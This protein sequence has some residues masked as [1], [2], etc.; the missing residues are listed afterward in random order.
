MKLSK[1]LFLALLVFTFATTQAQKV[2]IRAGLNISNI[3][4]S[5]AVD[6]KPLTGVYFGVFKEITL[7]P[8]IFYLQPELQYSM[9]GYKSGD[10][11]FS[12]GY[13]NIPVLA[14]VYA[15]KTFSLEAGPQ[16]G[17]KV[18]DNFEGNDG[19]NIKTF[20]TA[21]VGGLGYNFPMGLSINA[22]YAMGLSEIV[23]D[24]NFKNQVIQLGAAFKF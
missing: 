17:L 1:N 20:D 2:G 13:V 21:F 3:T 19:D 11:K 4:G 7:V 5:D 10:T 6:T 16:I 8:E 12:I 9:Q 15:I 14:K 22:R 23:K 24:S 18:N